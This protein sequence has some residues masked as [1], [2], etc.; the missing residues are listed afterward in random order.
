MCRRSSLEWVAAHPAAARL[1]DVR[2][3][4]ELA[5]PLGHVEG[6]ERCHSERDQ[7]P[8]RGTG[9]PAGGPRVP[10][11]RALRQ[12]RADDGG[13][14]VPEGGVDARWNDALERRTA[15]R[16][17]DAARDLGPRKPFQPHPERPP[18]RRRRCMRRRSRRRERRRGSPPT[19]PCARPR[20]PRFRPGRGRSSRTIPA[21]TNAA[22]IPASGG[23]SGCPAQGMRMV[24]ATV[25]GAPLNGCTLAPPSA[26]TRQLPAGVPSKRRP[27]ILAVVTCPAGENVT[28]TATDRPASTGSAQAPAARAVPAMAV[29]A[30]DLSKSVCGGPRVLSHT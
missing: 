25:I 2:E 6:V 17:A 29:V 22:S 19:T 28:C 20:W 16:H 30:A 10:L 9:I 7:V 21:S 4:S 26:R 1:V 24:A 12:G 11:R 27:L 18:A 13:H 15:S 23:G 8:R 14:G 3:P 5:G